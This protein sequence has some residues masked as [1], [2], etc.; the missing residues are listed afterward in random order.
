MAVKPTGLAV[1]D[2]RIYRAMRNS[3]KAEYFLREAGVLTDQSM[4]QVSADYKFRFV[5]SSH[6]RF[7]GEEIKPGT[8][9]VQSQKP[10][11]EERIK[12]WLE[13]L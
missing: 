7:F 9:I 6:R 13:R 1:N 3:P 2:E 10:L 5:I 12:Y 4:D 8:A 11:P